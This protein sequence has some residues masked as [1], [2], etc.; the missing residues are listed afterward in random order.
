MKG[1]HTAVGLLC[2]FSIF[3]CPKNNFQDTG[4]L[5]AVR[6]GY[7][8]PR[9]DNCHICCFCF[10]YLYYFLKSEN[11]HKKELCEVLEGLLSVDPTTELNEEY[12][13]LATHKTG[14]WI[15]GY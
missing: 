5:H 2:V 8:V 10:R 12:T 13:K 9:M 3:T 15:W 4:I 1:T 6:C 11:A 7:P 14:Q